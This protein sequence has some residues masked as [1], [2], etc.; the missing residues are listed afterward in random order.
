METEYKNL[1]IHHL[2]S[3]RERAKPAITTGESMK[4]AG[5]RISDAAQETK[6]Q[7]DIT[8][9]ERKIK[10]RKEQFGLDVYSKSKL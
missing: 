10:S 5:S 3:A 1:E 8:M 7:F 9:L 4:K 2:S 6:L